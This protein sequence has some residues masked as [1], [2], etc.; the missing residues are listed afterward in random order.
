MLGACDI[1]DQHPIQ[2]KKKYLSL[3]HALETRKISG[4]KVST[5]KI[6]FLCIFYAVKLFHYAQGMA[7]K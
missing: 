3:F 2:E 7:N 1:M 4:R 6:N 5:S